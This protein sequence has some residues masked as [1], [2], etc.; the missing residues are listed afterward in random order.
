MAWPSSVQ[1]AIQVPTLF[2][3]KLVGRRYTSLQ[4]RQF[5]Y[6]TVC[7]LLKFGFQPKVTRLRWSTWYTVAQ[8]LGQ[9][10]DILV[11][12][13][14]SPFEIRRSSLL[15][16]GKDHGIATVQRHKG[17]PTVIFLLSVSVLCENRRVRRLFIQCGEPIAQSIPA[18]VKLPLTKLVNI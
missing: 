9:F 8:C 14:F 15:K 10:N 12:V 13:L 6:V 3:A 5:S 4:L 11:L 18:V 17:L 7:C 1:R 2:E 16:A